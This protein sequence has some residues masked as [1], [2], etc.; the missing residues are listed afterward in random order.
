MQTIALNAKKQSYHDVR[1]FLI[2]RVQ[3]LTRGN[4]KLHDEL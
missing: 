3:R 4:A 1:N 2:K